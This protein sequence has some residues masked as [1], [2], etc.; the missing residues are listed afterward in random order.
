MRKEKGFWRIIE[1]MMINE[2]RMPQ[3]IVHFRAAVQN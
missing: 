1:I 3:A 2:S